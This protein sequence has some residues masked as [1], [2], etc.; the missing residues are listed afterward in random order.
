MRYFVSAL[1]T[2]FLL[3][4]LRAQE[5]LDYFLPDGIS[6]NSSIPTPKQVL[7]QE[8]GEWH[9]RHDQLVQYMHA[10][11]EA[12]NRVAI[13][14][15]GRT[16]ENRQLLSLVIT[17]PKNH[18]RLE[19][20]RQQHLQ[21]SDPE[22]SDNLNIENMPVVVQLSYSV[23]GNEPSGSNSSLLTAYHLAAAQGAEIDALLDNTIILVDPSINPDGLARFAQWAN[24][25][26]SKN[27]LVTDPDS[28]EYNEI[29]PGG[30]TNHYWFDLNRDWML[31]QHPESI[32]RI[33]RFQ[34][35]KPNILTDHHEMGSN[36][37]FFFQPGVP[38]RTHPLTP[39]TNQALT[40]AI[41]EYHAEELDN[42]QSLYYSKESFDDYYYGKGSTYP[43]VQGSIGILFEQASSRGH[44]QETIHGVLKFPFTIRN[45]FTATLSTLRAAADL[46]VELLEH[47]RTFYKE[48]V[49]AASRSTIKAYVFGDSEDQA[50]SF[51]LA[52]LINHHNIEVFELAED[53]TANGDT[54]KAGEAYV[55]PT[56]QPQYK[57]ITALFEVRNTFADSLFYDISG[58]T[59]PYAFNMPFAELSNRQ[60]KTSQ[61][62]DAFMGEMPSTGQVIGGTSNYAYV[63]EW[64]EYYSPRA[65]YKLLDAGIRAKVAT[66]QFSAIT[67][68]GE[69]AFDYGTILIPMGVQE[70]QQ[71]VHQLISEISHENYIDVYSLKTGLSVSG[72]DLGS[73]RFA[74]LRK[75]SVAVIGGSGTNSY[76]I[77]EMW[78]LLDQR[79]HMPLTILDKSDL[80]GADL[81][82]YTVIIMTGYSYNDVSNGAA[83]AIKNWVRNGGVL[84]TMK[85]G[86]FWANRQELSDVSF[87]ETNTDE[88]EETEL[89]PYIMQGA[90][91]GAGVIGG[92]IFNAKLDLTHPLGYGYNAEEITVFRNSTIFLQKGENPYSTPLVYTDSPLASGYIS[93]EN[94]QYLANSAAIVVSRF[95]G[96]KVIAMAD[97]PNFRAFWY[98][99]NKLFANTLF[100]GPTIRGSSAN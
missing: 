68:I 70:D 74:N 59:M 7:N 88:V 42:I 62:G 51:H 92:A 83:E 90:D 72:I 5:T 1:F 43:D 28:R 37:T 20:I 80:G 58:W 86:I 87:V 96:G 73:N 38:S 66:G 14:E 39:E 22:V 57:L 69:K 67:G 21:L 85:Q 45:H 64:D 11:A 2:L 55:V 4:P 10:V 13:M 54:F 71:K 52:E 76:E 75:P 18:A 41:A 61:L 50:R 31:V 97:N 95:G 98:G 16:Y 47:N 25:H 44:A 81:S 8:V 91:Q 49:R 100:F 53:I 79:Y 24:M 82:R 94:A 65:L 15:Y 89:R 17:S 32:G 35:W 3:V 99:T 27:T 30:R 48:A 23:H 12:S 60:F 9:I 40:G 77:G 56:G 33:A 63:F 34:D 93:D 6:Y 26:K 84:L 46:R 19:E 36:A 29:W 78:H